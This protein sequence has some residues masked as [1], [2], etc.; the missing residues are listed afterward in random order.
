MRDTR[1]KPNVLLINCDDMGYGDL[2]CYGSTRNKTPSIDAMAN[3]GMRFTDAYCASPV[4]S[5]SRAG[6]LTGCDPPHLDF[7]RVLFPADPMG[8]N[9]AEYTLPML[10]K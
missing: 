7:N 3:E 10:F 9:P 6:L 1:N 8:L 4:C 2:G 5:P